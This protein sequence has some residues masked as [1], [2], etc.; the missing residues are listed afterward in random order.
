MSGLALDLA[1]ALN[2]V[3]FARRLGI[4][5]DPWQAALLVSESREVILN[6]SRQSGKSTITA[7]LALHRARF[8]PR[9]S[10]PLTVL[11]LSPSMRQSGELYKKVT[12]SQAKLGDEVVES[13][14]VGELALKNGS[15]IICLPGNA[16]TVRGYSAGL[17]IIDECAHVEGDDLYQ[18]VRPMLAVTGGRLILL[19]TPWGKRGFYHA[20][21]TFGG[22][23]WERILVTASECPRIDPAWL[24]NERKQL[25]EWQFRQEYECSFE[26]AEGSLFKHD[27]VL[28]AL[29]DDLE[30]WFTET[31]ELALAAAGGTTC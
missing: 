13:E 7:V 20:V 12:D 9:G 15:R 21:W 24:A 10:G 25:S 31:P 1:C 14:T 16:S 8:R 23:S 19:S 3:V 28:A 18:A 27:T 5:P 11:L 29:D 17:C 6:C 22:L 4:E 26:D 30:P 2:P